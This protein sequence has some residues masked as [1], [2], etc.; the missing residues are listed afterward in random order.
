MSD[1][2]AH[3]TDPLIKHVPLRG[4]RLGRWSL[5]WWSRQITR[6]FLPKPNPHSYAV[7]DPFCK[8][9]MCALQIG[10]D[11]Y[12]LDYGLRLPQEFM[13]LDE[14]LRQ[15]G[16]PLVLWGASVGPFEAAPAF[17]PEM[18]THLR[19]MRAILV[20][21]SD[22]YEYLKQ[23]DVEANLH[24]MSDPAFAM[25]PAQP[26]TERL[27]C[28]LPA[29]AIG[30]NLSPLMAKYVTNGDINAWVKLSADIVDDILLR[31]HDATFCSFPM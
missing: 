5:P 4:K 3:E 8:D 19:A 6:S 7:L 22:S 11:N 18:L 24:C 2:A 9:A 30:L 17:G 27:G 21:E 23:H 1:Q 29:G 20:R 14:Y 12:T 31:R 28:P 16:V 15:R 10:G 13:R 25:E 26:P